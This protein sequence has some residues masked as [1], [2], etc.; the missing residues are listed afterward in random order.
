VSAGGVSAQQ[1][2]EI[3]ARLKAATPGPWTWGDGWRDLIYLGPDQFEGAD[4]YADLQLTGRDQRTIIGIRIDHYEPIWDTATPADE[5]NEADREFIAHAPADVAA[6]VEHVK[7][8]RAA[9]QP[10]AGWARACSI[11]A[12][13]DPADDDT[14]NEL[15]PVRT[16][17]LRRAAAALGTPEEPK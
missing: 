13:D 5:P 10:F 6:L 17:D 12:T 1:L 3:E 8:L 15:Y 16:G 2:A 11:S 9:L 7:A 4:K 14:D